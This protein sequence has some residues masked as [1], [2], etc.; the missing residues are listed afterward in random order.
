MAT[1]RMCKDD[2]DLI[3][4]IGPDGIFNFRTGRLGNKTNWRTVDIE[5]IRARLTEVGDA[6][7]RVRDDV[8]DACARRI[9]VAIRRFTLEAAA[10]RRNSGA[11]RVPRPSR[12]RALGAARSAERRRRPRPS[13]PALQRLLLDEFQDTDPIQIELA[14]RIAAAD[15]L[16]A[17]AGSAHWTSVPVAPGQIFVVGDPKQSIYRFRRADI[18]T[19]MAARDTLRRRRRSRPRTHDQLPHRRPRDRLGQ[20][21]LRDAHD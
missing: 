7:A 20:P 16:S 15:P 2:L 12:A 17:E 5:T 4:A 19:F 13:S 14:V 21:G 11:A 18:G 3:A 9:G 10:E 6:M 1:L 8:A